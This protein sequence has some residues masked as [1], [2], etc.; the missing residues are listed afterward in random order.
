MSERIE[1]FDPTEPGEAMARIEAIVLGRV[2]VDLTPSSPR[3]SLAEATSFLR[4][5]GGYAGNVGTGLA[6]LGVRTAV[7][8]AVGDDGHGQHLLSSLVHEGIDVTHVAIRP[9]TRTQVAFFEA[10]PPDSFPVSFYRP[11]PA[12]DTL[13][14]GASLPSDDLPCVLFEAAASAPATPL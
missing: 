14:D 5:V 7:V 4:A 8:S 6:R 3:T 1:P 12:P 11:A 13:L 10:W 9:G 2:G